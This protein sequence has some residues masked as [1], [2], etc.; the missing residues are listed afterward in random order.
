MNAS[1]FIARARSAL[2]S[3]LDR[4]VPYNQDNRAFN[5]RTNTPPEGGLDCGTFVRWAV[6]PDP[7]ASSEPAWHTTG[8]VSDA[9][10][11][12]DFFERIVDPRPGCLVVYPD[13]TAKADVTGTVTHHDGHVA[14]VTEVRTVGSVLRPTRVIHCSSMI[15]GLRAALMPDADRHAI[16]ETDGKLF[17]NWNPIYASI[18]SITPDTSQVANRD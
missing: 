5:P 17:W 1:E 12:Q 15:E 4:G 18:R 14:I 8:I 3:A 10:T 6:K 7:P 13:Y 9:T 2:R 11:A 16:A